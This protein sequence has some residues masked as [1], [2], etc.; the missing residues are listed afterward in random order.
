MRVYLLDYFGLFVCSFDM[1]CSLFFRPH[2]WLSV[3]G[4]RYA[5]SASHATQMSIQLNTWDD[6]NEE[7][8]TGFVMNQHHFHDHSMKNLRD[9]FASLTCGVLPVMPVTSAL[10]VGLVRMQSQKT[11]V[12]FNSVQ[13]LH[14]PICQ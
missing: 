14:Q 12:T 11:S 1:F 13:G 10:I 5:V 2:S 9:A 8:Y 3:E 6:L 4:K 7:I